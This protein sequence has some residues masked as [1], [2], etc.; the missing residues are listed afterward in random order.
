MTYIHFK[1][2]HFFSLYSQVAHVL[3]INDIYIN[4]MTRISKIVF[5]ILVTK[6]TVGDEA[7]ITR[8]S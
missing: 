5:P 7:C 2:T 8:Q 4:S 6:T 1:R 3:G